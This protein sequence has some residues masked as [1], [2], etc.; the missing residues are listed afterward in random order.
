MYPRD[1][2]R[3]IRWILPLSL[4]L[5]LFV[6]FAWIS[7]KS[8]DWLNLG[9]QRVQESSANFCALVSVK[10]EPP[11]WLS[12]AWKRRDSAVERVYFCTC[13]AYTAQFNT[14]Q[15][16]VC[17]TRH[18]FARPRRATANDLSRLA[19]RRLQGLR[20]SVSRLTASGSN[21]LM[22]RFRPVECTTGETHDWLP[23][24]HKYHLHTCMIYLDC[25]HLRPPPKVRPPDKWAHT[26]H[27]T[28]HLLGLH[29]SWIDPNTHLWVLNRNRNGNRNLNP[30]KP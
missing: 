12:F 8:T 3:S 6:W 20:L 26:N 16:P 23:L 27:S 7:L 13:R 9:M 15:Y 10:V 11:L 29:K 22:L 1:A 24:F 30:M 5:W 17:Q 18:R 14:M 28:I 19:W 25:K 2:I 4:Y 21:R